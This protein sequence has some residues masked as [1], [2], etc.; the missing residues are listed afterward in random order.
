[1]QIKIT[2]TNYE[3]EWYDVSVGEEEG[4]SVELMRLQAAGITELKVIR[5]IEQDI[6]KNFALPYYEEE[7]KKHFV[8]DWKQPSFVNKYP[9]KV[10]TPR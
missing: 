3:S 2:G 7:G 10:K 6:T 8:G 5:Q 4:V 1:M 9:L